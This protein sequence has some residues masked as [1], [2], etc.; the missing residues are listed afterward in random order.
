MCVKMNVCA[1]S[2]FTNNKGHFI[3]STD[4]W[5]G[6]KL[7]YRYDDTETLKIQ[8]FSYRNNQVEFESILY[9]VL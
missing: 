2:A 5:D 4:Q 6:K 9:I 3:Q 8:F 1:K 7:F